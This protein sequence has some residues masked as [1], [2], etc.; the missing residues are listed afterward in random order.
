M[1]PFVVF[2]IRGNA[3]LSS[4]IILAIGLMYM[5]FI[6]LGYVPLSFFRALHVED[7]ELCQI[8]HTFMFIWFLSLT[9]M[10]WCITLTDLYTL[11]TVQLNQFHHSELSFLY[12]LNLVC[13]YFIEKNLH[14]CSVRRLAYHYFIVSLSGFGVRI[15]LA[16]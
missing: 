12:V 16:L 15:I 5:S 2:L 7:T 4:S 3:L 9:L 14:L 10:W 1:A 13:Q 11:L 6:M 8:L